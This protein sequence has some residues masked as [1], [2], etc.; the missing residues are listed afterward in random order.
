MQRQLHPLEDDAHSPLGLLHLLRGPASH[1][2]VIRL[3]HQ[4]PYLTPPALPHRA[5]PVRLRPKTTR[6]ERAHP[7]SPANKGRDALPRS[8]AQ[9]H[10][11]PLTFPRTQPREET[12]PL[13]V[14]A[15]GKA[16]PNKR[17]PYSCLF[18]RHERDDF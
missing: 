2:E 11:W 15:K 9:R 13:P 8:T 10:P 3:A 14:P 16:L 18:D 12:S 6:G 17:N 5:E 7:L 4:F 1:H